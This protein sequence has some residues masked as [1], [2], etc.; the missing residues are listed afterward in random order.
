MKFNLLGTFDM[1]S[2]SAIISDPSH[3]MG[4][5]GQVFI[6][7]IK[8]G[9]WEAYTANFDDNDVRRGRVPMLLAFHKESLF[10]VEELKIVDEILPVGINSGIAGI[11]D[12]TKYPSLTDDTGKFVTDED[13]FRRARDATSGLDRAGLICGGVLFRSNIDEGEFTCYTLRQDNTI[14]G[15]MID[16]DLYDYTFDVA[17]VYSELCRLGRTCKHPT[18]AV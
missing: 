12:L 1:T 17:D 6:E 14:M 10:S 2:D 11:F 5:W 13:W 9:I 7:D 4:A 3:P 8:S 16:F 15:I 18:S